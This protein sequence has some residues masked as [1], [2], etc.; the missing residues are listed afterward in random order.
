MI[1]WNHA[2]KKEGNEECALLPRE[3]SFKKECI[4]GGEMTKSN[5]V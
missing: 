2:E 5:R 1:L 4:K 3:E